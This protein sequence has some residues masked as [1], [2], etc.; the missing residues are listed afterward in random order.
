MRPVQE[1]CAPPSFDKN[2]GKFERLTFLRLLNLAIKTVPK[3]YLAATS[4]LFQWYISYLICTKCCLNLANILPIYHQNQGHISIIRKSKA[5]SFA[6]VESKLLCIETGFPIF[7][8]KSLT[9]IFSGAKLFSYQ[10]DWNLRCF[11]AV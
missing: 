11:F 7:L 5:L 4:G 1:Q 6:L 2:W 9:Q 10:K 8:S 3:S